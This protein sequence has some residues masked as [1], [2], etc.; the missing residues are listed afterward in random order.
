MAQ[1]KKS[2]SIV[3]TNYKMEDFL[4]TQVT[5][6]R[7]KAPLLTVTSGLHMFNHLV[8]SHNMLQ[9]LFS[10]KGFSLTGLIRGSDGAASLQYRIRAA[11]VWLIF[12]RLIL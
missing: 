11:I 3:T 12:S 7:D 8:L 10:L 5:V 4:F 9:L 1:E 2:Q 6:Y